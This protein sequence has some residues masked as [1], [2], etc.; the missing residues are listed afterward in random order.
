MEYGNKFRKTRE[1]KQIQTQASHNGT[2]S[3]PPTLLLTPSP[4]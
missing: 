3:P 1:N 4:V 2:H